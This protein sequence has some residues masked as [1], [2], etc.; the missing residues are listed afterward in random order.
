MTS[1]IAV[2]FVLV[3]L[4]VTASAVALASTSGSAPVPAGAKTEPMTGLCQL[5]HIPAQVPSD[6]A[7]I[8]DLCNDHSNVIAP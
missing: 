4:A 6:P 5:K 3:V 8:R 1:R 2:L 7:A